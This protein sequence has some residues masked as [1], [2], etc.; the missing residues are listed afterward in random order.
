MGTDI[1]FDRLWSHV[2]EESIAATS[3][4]HG[5]KH[6]RRVE[7]NGIR[8]AKSTGAD[9]VVVRLF[10]LFHDSCRWDDGTDP[11]HGARAAEYASELR[12]VLFDLPEDAF[13]RL[14]EACVWHTDGLRHDDPTI[15]ACWD[16]DRL[17]LGRVGISPEPEYMSTELGRRLAGHRRFQR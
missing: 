16:A 10:A 6:W 17:D 15:G 14:H 9:I 3:S 1:D 13:L 4:I 2:V 7:R 5:T 12:G 11:D 8:L